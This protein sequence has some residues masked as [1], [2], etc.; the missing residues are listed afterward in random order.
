MN[1]VILIIKNKAFHFAGLLFLTIS[2]LSCNAKGWEEGYSTYGF[3]FSPN[4]TIA[5]LS[6]KGKNLSPVE[7]YILANAY[8]KNG[9]LKKSVIQYANSAFMTHRNFSMKA[10]PS[11][12]YN[13]MNGMHIKS[14]YYYDAAY[15]IGRIFFD[16]AEYEYA[17]KFAA[18]VPSKDISLYREAIILEA[19]S[20]E[21]MKQYDTALELLRTAL[22]KFTQLQLTPVMHIRI[23]SIL[24]KKK[25]YSAALDEFA[26]SL[27]ISSEGWQGA[28]AGK[29]SYLII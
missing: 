16:Y 1:I 22:P 4:E 5:A 17:V 7:H 3:Y 23:A 12:V 19:R 29:E 13:F 9:N 14:D 18:M 11:P 8:K 25:D 28:T 21:Q 6:T 10:F 26:V 15:E 24:A 27:K 2:L 20:Y